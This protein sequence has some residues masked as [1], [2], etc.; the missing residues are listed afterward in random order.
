M[1]APTRKLCLIHIFPSILNNTEFLSGAPGTPLNCVRYWQNPWPIGNIFPEPAAVSFT[2][3][4]LCRSK[5][6]Q[7]VPGDVQLYAI[8]RY[9]KHRSTFLTFRSNL[10]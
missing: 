1:Q 6:V 8:F 9:G 4:L 2:L 3:N 5:R 10:N 7:I